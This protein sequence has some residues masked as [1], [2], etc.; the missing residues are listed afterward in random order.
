MN[1]LT[2]AALALA[3]LLPIIVAMYLLKLRRTEQVVSSVYLWRRMVRDVEANAPWQ[4]LRRNLL[5]FLQLLFLLALILAL[6]QPFTW[7]EGIA[8]QA[9]IFIIDNSASMAATDTPPSRLEAAKDQ[10]RRLVDGLPDDAR[11]TIM[12]AAENT[13]VLAA[14]TQN[15]RQIYQ[16]IESIQPTA[17]TSNLTTAIELASAIASRQPDTEVIILS[18]GRSDLPDRLALRGRVRYFPIGISGDNQAIS[19]ITLEPSSTGSDAT[20]FIQVTNYAEETANRRMELYAGSMLVNA[21]DLEIPS[22]G[23]QAIVADDLPPDTTFIEARLQSTDALPLDDRAWAV[24]RQGEPVSVTLVTEGNIFLYT[25]LTLL[26]G[27]EVDVV[28]PEDYEEGETGEGGQTSSPAGQSASELPSQLTIFDAY[29]PITATLPSGSLLFI[30]PPRSSE[31]F[32]V[33]G[34]IEGPALRVVDSTDPLVANLGLSEVNILDAVRISLPLWARTV[35]AADTT[36]TSSP[37]LMVGT[38][39]GRRAAILAFDLRRSD[40]PLQVA[41][42][43]LVANLTGWLA[44]GS[45][46]GLPEQVAPGAA[47]T[48]AL[49]P[50]V[51]SITVSRPDGSRTGIS[52]SDGRAVFAGT[53]QLGIYNIS[54]GS[55]GSI[56]FAV[57]LFSPQ[58]SDISPAQSLPVLETA[59]AGDAERPQQGRREW[60][61]PLAYAG[62]AFLVVEWLVYQRAVLVKLWRRLVP[63]QPR[64]DF[65]S[66][67]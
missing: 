6:A 53:D 49:P 22:G 4:R 7:A 43:L 61:R 65:R 17:G 59:G 67:R 34:S 33:T 32:S 38:V 10:A 55:E 62:L 42:P 19:L 28:A 63:Q 64:E 57:N 8:G 12:S 11:V 44:P 13:Q 47:V 35:L 46:S 30:A 23:I 29:V 15:R 25:A 24:K 37:A 20:A 31:Y 1:F 3:V 60:W 14:S 50:E 45:S 52:V 40:L 21:Y 2:P 26:P 27:L 18:D 66:L 9:A 41:F 36:S 56:S 48:L 54:W 5:M 39:E 16:A 58:E 51:S